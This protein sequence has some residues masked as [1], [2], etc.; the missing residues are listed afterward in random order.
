MAYILYSA[1]SDEK[2]KITD[3]G[4]YANCLYYGLPGYKKQKSLTRESMQTIYIMA[5]LDVHNVTKM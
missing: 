2:T 3:K 5:C 4:V 1:A